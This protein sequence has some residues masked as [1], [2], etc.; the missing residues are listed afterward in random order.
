MDLGLWF[1]DR[2]CHRADPRRYER[3][4]RHQD[5]AHGGVFIVRDDRCAAVIRAIDVVTLVLT[6]FLFGLVTPAI[7]MG[8]PETCGIRFAG[9]HL[10]IPDTQFTTNYVAKKCVFVIE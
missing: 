4:V 9:R 2:H 8:V 10:G 7:P 3:S 1:L 6:T 5:N